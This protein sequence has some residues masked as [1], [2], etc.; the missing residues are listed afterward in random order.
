MFILIVRKARRICIREGQPFPFWNYF[1]DAGPVQNFLSDQPVLL[2]LIW[3]FRLCNRKWKDW[4]NSGTSCF[5]LTLIHLVFDGHAVRMPARTLSVEKRTFIALEF[6]KTQDVKGTL[7]AFQLRWPEESRPSKNTP[8]R[9]L[10][11]LKENHTLG[12]L[13]PKEIKKR[14]FVSLK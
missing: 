10:T 8:G 1:L 9:L 5:P 4:K 7:D 14:V 11:K 2:W 13:Y 3:V 6:Q 12:Y